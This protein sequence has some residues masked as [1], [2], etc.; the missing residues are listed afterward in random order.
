MYVI[1]SGNIFTLYSTDS[2]VN[3]KRQKVCNYDM[4][5]LLGASKGNN[6]K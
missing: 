5:N 3:E 1:T 2:Q 6:L 4:A